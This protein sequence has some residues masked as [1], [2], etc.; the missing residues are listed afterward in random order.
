MCL[1]NLQQKIVTGTPPTQLSEFPAFAKEL[2]AN[3]PETDRDYVGLQKPYFSFPFLA[4]AGAYSFKRTEN[5][6][7]LQDIGV[8]NSGAIEG[9]K[10]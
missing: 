9:L 2:K 5:G 1:T 8:D 6:Y 4:S 3:E 10:A 7:D